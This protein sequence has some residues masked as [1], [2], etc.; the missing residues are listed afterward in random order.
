MR[1]I[2]AGS[3][4]FTYY[5]EVLGIVADSNYRIT[6]IVS[7]AARGVDTVGEEIAK[8]YNIPFVRFPADWDR[9]GLSA[10]RIRNAEMA[11]NADALIAVWN[12]FSPGTR[13]MIDIANKRGLLVHIGMV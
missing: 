4:D 5:E 8:A 1:T 3:R 11:K 7:G 10:G 9:Y 6:Q 2:I 12:G 13:N